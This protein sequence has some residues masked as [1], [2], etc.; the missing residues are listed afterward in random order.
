MPLYLIWIL[1]HW[2]ENIQYCNCSSFVHCITI[3]GYL[4]YLFINIYKSHFY[5][6]YINIVKPEWK[7]FFA[8]MPV[9]L[10]CRPSCKIF[11]SHDPIKVVQAKGQYM[12]DEKGQRYLDCINNVAHGKHHTVTHTHTC[13]DFWEEK[14]VQYIRS[15][16]YHFYVIISTKNWT[17]DLKYGIKVRGMW[18]ILGS[19][20]T[21][22]HEWQMYLLYKDIKYCTHNFKWL[23]LHYCRETGM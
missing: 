21:R 8:L 3:N 18:Y 5:P 7:A 4:W 6:Y 2:I 19:V 10:L 20:F 14:Y 17:R 1:C 16:L 22:M 15:V 9:L 11:F 12:Y 23:K 13:K